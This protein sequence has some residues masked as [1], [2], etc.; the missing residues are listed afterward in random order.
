MDE[1]VGGVGGLDCAAIRRAVKKGVFMDTVKPRDGQK[2]KSVVKTPFGTIT[3]RNFVKAAAA[4]AA[5]AGIAGGLL[6]CASNDE[7]QSG[8]GAAKQD[9]WIP[10]MCNMCFNHC[11]ILGHVVD[12][13]LVEIKGDDRSP[14]G[15][16]HL[17]G[18]G[19]AGIMQLYDPNRITVP[20]RR[21]NPNKGIGI[22]PQWEEI[23]WD[24]AYDE[25]L[26]KLDEQKEKNKPVV[27][28]ALI[29]SI[30]SWIDS[31]TWLGTNGNIPLPL[32][33]D[34]CGA[35]THPITSIM[36]G[37][38]NALPDYAHI[39]YLMQFGTQAGV[40]TRHGTS[41]DAK[42]FAESRVNGCKLV[43]FDPHMSASAEQADEWVP[44]RPGTDAAVALAMANL[45]VNEY[46]IY[47][48]EFLTNRTNGPA[49]VNPETKRIVRDASSNKSLYWDTVDN[50][51]KPYDKCDKPALE[52]D[53]E[54]DGVKVRTAFTLFK[55]HVAKYT[56]EYA[57]EVTTVPADTTRRIAKEFGEAACIGQTEVVDGIEVPYRPVAVDTFSGIARHKHGF[58]THWAI[59]QL[60]NIVG[61]TFARGGYLGYYTANN[62]GFYEDDP[63]HKWEWSIWD[64][65]GL[66]EYQAM[67]HGWP[68]QESYYD[69]IRNGSYEPTSEAM[70]ELQPLTMDQHFAYIS[71][72]YPDLYNTEPSEMAFCMASN[73]IKNWCDNDYQA[74]L[75]ESFNYI[76]G[77]DIYL[78]ESSY[79]YDLIIPEP[80]YLERY[81]PLPLSFNN[82]RVP[83]IPEVPFIV[84]SRIPIVPA[85]DDCPSALDT[86]GALA[87][88]AGKTAE[89]AEALNGYYH[90]D[91][92][93]A[94]PT[95]QQITAKAVVD[96]AMKSLAGHERGIDWFK[97][98]G[99]WTR[100][101]KA[102]EVYAFAAGKEGRIPIYFDFMLEAK[103]KIEAEVAK[104]GIEWET[105]DYIPLPDWMPCCD[106]EV[107]EEGFD[108]YPVYWT[109]AINT[110][111]WQV[112]NAWINEINE[113]D[114]I[115]YFLE[116][117]E[118]T[119]AARGIKT[120][121][122]VR[123]SNRDG[124]VVE[125]IAVLSSGVHPEVV[126]SMGGHLGSRSAFQPVSENKGYAVNHLVPCGDPKRMEYVGSGVDQCVRCKLEKIS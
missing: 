22:D 7:N 4:T 2:E 53:F 61:S 26:A 122:K 67:A 68:E 23:T 39:K 89:Y 79:Y 63:G 71:Q 99:V 33:A 36:T 17:C 6:G 123:L 16:G 54:V 45:L 85:K 62:Y 21:T 121:D 105:D 69:R 109:N 91:K 97:E 10:S 80:C 77:M 18:K 73:P 34:I 106:Y 118:E 11:S 76:F 15:W 120:G 28:F 126:A 72:L 32:K 103:E 49:L 101:R 48:E 40:A 43:D 112:E 37:C 70:E 104:L 25:I 52:G 66:I 50:T 95:D 111:T 29:T 102:D 96:A 124:N 5:T 42:F 92:E 94:L 19:T 90:I 1:N 35:P 60:N 88:K 13:K 114:D 81:D 117:N 44:I 57:E 27:V 125:G 30:I 12:G 108:L 113:A 64:E 98:N 83:G 59:L 87:E 46:G 31:M 74:R 20:L 58:I 14:A 93:H 8:G 78:N 47:D 119:G 84:G 24:E 55:E 41:I 51:A 38:G 9:E 75:L 3:R 110:D 82:H 100:E 86:F 65:D 115:S 116:I 56:P 107:E